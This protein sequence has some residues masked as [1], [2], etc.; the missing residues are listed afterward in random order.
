MKNKSWQH[1]FPTFF[2]KIFDKNKDGKL[3]TTETIFRDAFLNDINRKQKDD[4][5]KKQ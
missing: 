1:P 3:N 5:N 2:D 4:K